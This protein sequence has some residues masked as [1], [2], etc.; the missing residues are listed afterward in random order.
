M[1]EIEENEGWI[2]DLEDLTFMNTNTK[3]VVEMEKNE[4]AY[5]GKIKTLP[6][7]I[8]EKLSRIKDGELIIQKAVIDAEEIFMKT[9]YNKN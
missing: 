2:V 5:I 3:I 1:E 4:K 7:E 9:Y 8:M 6:I